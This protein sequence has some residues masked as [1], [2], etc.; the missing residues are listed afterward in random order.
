MSQ[1]PENCRQRLAAAGKAYPKSNCA[2][3]GQFFPKAKECDA[4]LVGKCWSCKKPVSFEQWRDADGVCPHCCV[5]IEGLNAPACST[6]ND[7][8]KEHDNGAA[9]PCTSCQGKARTQVLTVTPRP[10]L[11][12]WAG[13]MPESNGRSN[14]TVI[15]HRGNITEGVCV[16]RSEYPGRA[17]YEADTFRWLIGEKLD[18]PCPTE[19]DSELR[20]DY[21]PPEREVIFQYRECATWGGQ[22]SKWQ[23]CTEDFYLKVKAVPV[24]HGFHR[25]SRKLQEV[26]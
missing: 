6:C 21:R 9:H 20:S 2:A 11:E 18:K 10:V 23:L 15:L 5:E 14:H 26:L 8:G 1:P 3:C 7:T 25:E 13:P 4:A 19:Y 16:Y 17:E 24:E 22:W 12:V